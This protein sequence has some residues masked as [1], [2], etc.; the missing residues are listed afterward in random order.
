MNLFVYFP[1]S[2]SKVM[3]AIGISLFLLRYVRGRKHRGSLLSTPRDALSSRQ[4]PNSISCA[5]VD[6]QDVVSSWSDAE[7]GPTTFL[8]TAMLKMGGSVFT[9]AT[10]VAMGKTIGIGRQGNAEWL[11]LFFLGDSILWRAQGRTCQG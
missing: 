10:L 1:C 5:F 7:R 9:Y 6:R 2:G 11:A 3:I 4:H 8:E